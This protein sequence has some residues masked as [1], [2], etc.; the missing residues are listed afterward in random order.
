MYNGLPVFSDRDINRPKTSN[1][2]GIDTNNPGNLVNGNGKG[3]IGVYL[4]SNGRYYTVFETIND[5]YEAM[6]EEIVA[7]KQNLQNQ[8]RDYGPIPQTISDKYAFIYLFRWT[9]LWTKLKN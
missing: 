5:G 3:A 8:N 7:I 6:I 9:N 1:N 4:S 2:I